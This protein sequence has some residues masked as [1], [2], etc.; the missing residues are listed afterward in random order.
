MPAADLE[1]TLR[2]AFPKLRESGARHVHYKVCS[3]FD[4]SPSIGSIGR[5]IEVGCEVF[6][7]EYVPLVVGSPNLGRY[8]VFGNLFAEAGIGAAG[9]VHRLDR[10]PSASRHPTTPA[11]ESDLRRYLGRQ[12]GR[13]IRLLDILTLE[14]PVEVLRTSFANLAAQ[15]CILLFDVLRP[16]QLMRIGQL[17]DASVQEPKSFFSVG[18]SAVETALVDHWRSEGRIDQP[19][20][21]PK[22]ANTERLLVLSGSCSTVTAQQIEWALSHGFAELEL[23]TARLIEANDSRQLE[24]TCQRAR[25]LVQ[26]SHLIVHSSRGPADP[27]IVATR[28]A[29]A[30]SHG[31]ESMVETNR[32]IAE[33]LTSIGRACLQ[34]GLVKRVC[35]A[36]GD[37]SSHVARSLGIQALEMVA[38]HHRG[39][40]LCRARATGLADGVEFVFKGG[41]VGNENYFQAVSSGIVE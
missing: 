40:P 13:E 35:L 20:V 27:R 29:V 33:F 38:P 1:S 4:S 31:H 8:C 6:D 19:S 5:A 24:G 2:S 3:T 34:S 7:Q 25:E 28:E 26:A 12:T 39:A 11:T 17:I 10:H 21:W 15:K 16:S 36:G 32:Q 30:A 41:Q 9:E 14:Q 23:D 18:S 37:T 22:I